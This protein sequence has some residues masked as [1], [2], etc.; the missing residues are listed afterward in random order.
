[1]TVPPKADRRAVPRFKVW[2]ACSILSRLS[3]EDF[4]KQAVLGYVKDL[5]REAVAVLLPSNETYGVDASSLGQ[6]V[7][8]TLAL[9]VGYVRLSATLVRYSPDD[10]GK[11]VFVFRIQDSKDRS[12][13]EEYMDTVESE[14]SRAAK[15][16]VRS[17]L[18]II[19]NEL[20]PNSAD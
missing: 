9:P 20:D 18:A 2:V 4:R 14:S 1:M 7:Q 11:L 19:E 8:M 12:K 15:D 3:D 5:S 17:R 10:S 16:S 6:Q 13:Y